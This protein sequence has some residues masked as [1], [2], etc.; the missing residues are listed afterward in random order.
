MPN[1]HQRT[2]GK[3]LEEVLW[4]AVAKHPNSSRIR[5]KT[6]RKTRK[7][8]WNVLKSYSPAS[9]T[10]GTCLEE[11]L[12]RGGSETPEQHQDSCPRHAKRALKNKCLTSPLENILPT[13]RQMP[14]Y[15]LSDT[16]LE[17]TRTAAG[18]P[19]TQTSR[20]APPHSEGVGGYFLSS[21][22]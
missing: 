4:E 19:P 9:K 22:V 3:S 12:W 11:V 13:P 20:R 7:K 6:I 18:L 17:N 16:P 5:A 15:S 21:E 10:V 2:I 14:Q 8:K 1:Q